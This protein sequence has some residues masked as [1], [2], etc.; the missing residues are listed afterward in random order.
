MALKRSL[1]FAFDPVGAAGGWRDFKGDAETKE[2][3]EKIAEKLY[4]QIQIV[5]TSHEETSVAHASISSI[6]SIGSSSTTNTDLRPLPS[7]DFRV[8]AFY[9]SAECSTLASCFPQKTSKRS[10]AI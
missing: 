4:G 6:R 2:E 10:S 3:A 7:R 9:F 5:D 1:I 8:A